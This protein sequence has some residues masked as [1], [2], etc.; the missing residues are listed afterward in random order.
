M[1]RPVFITLHAGS[2]FLTAIWLLLLLKVAL[3]KK[4]FEQ[5]YA[6]VGE[7]KYPVTEADIPGARFKPIPD[8]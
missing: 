3:V 2:L 5:E 7:G 4:P 8:I 6:K 1:V